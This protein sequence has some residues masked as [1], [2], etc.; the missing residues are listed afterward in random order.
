MERGKNV[1]AG[2]LMVG[3]SHAVCALG[4]VVAAGHLTGITPTRL[5]L[6]FY[7]IGTLAPDIDGDGSIARPG[8]ILKIFI[9][10][11]LAKIVDGIGATISAMA[12]ALCG[13]R[14]I[15]HW[16]A[17]GLALIA[18]GYCLG[19]NALM[20]FGFGYLVHILCDTLTYQ[21]IPL[22]APLRFRRYSLSM[23]KTGSLPELALT[24]SVLIA[25]IYWGFDLLPNKLQ[26]G[27][28]EIYSH[29]SK[30]HDLK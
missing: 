18:C 13:H 30:Q 5:E 17:V 24:T 16:P 20:W 29:Y 12:N 6:F 19:L 4:A 11:K 28:H 26:N 8:T 23:F 22:L 21:G 10:W 15:F 1:S 3:P 27:F 9:G 7:L 25:T 14:G 2:I